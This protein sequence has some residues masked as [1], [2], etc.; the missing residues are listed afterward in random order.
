MNRR[1]ALGPLSVLAIAGVLAACSL[2]TPTGCPQTIEAARALD[3]ADRAFVGGGYVIR[4]VPSPDPEFRGYDVNIT[5]PISPSGP[6][7]TAFLRV[8]NEIPGIQDGD[9]VLL[10][11]PRARGVVVLPGA[12]PALTVVSED[13]LDQ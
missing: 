3:P 8:A 2:P 13:E 5:T 10:I 11:G 9:P 6:L 12:C 7:N 4:F 1:L